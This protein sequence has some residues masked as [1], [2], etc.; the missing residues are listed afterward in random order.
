MPSE[1]NTSHQA[2]QDSAEE[3]GLNQMTLQNR[4]YSISSHPRSPSEFSTALQ[5]S[6]SAGKMPPQ[7]TTGN[8]ISLP[9]SGKWN[10]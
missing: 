7:I 8:R 2:V 1:N 10:S 9:G 4:D 6:I 5:S 3:M